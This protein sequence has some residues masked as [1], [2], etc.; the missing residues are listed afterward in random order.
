MYS[1]TSKLV[2]RRA[3]PKQDPKLDGVSTE[4]M[5]S[6]LRMLHAFPSRPTVPVISWSFVMPSSRTH[7]KVDIYRYIYHVARPSVH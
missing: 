5:W 2:L 1:A 7:S 4:G 6:F 3:G